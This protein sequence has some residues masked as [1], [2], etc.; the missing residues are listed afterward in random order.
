MTQRAFFSLREYPELERVRRQWREIRDEGQKL[1]RDMVWIEDERTN[2]RVWAFAPLKPENVDRTPQ[3]DAMSIAFR[4]KAPETVRLVQTIPRVLGYGFSLLLAGSR[5][6]THAHVNP[7][8][9]AMLGLSVGDSCWLTVG[10]ETYKIRPGHIL[11]FDYTLPHEVSNKS[12]KDR[13]VLLILLPNK[14]LC[15][16]GKC[17]RGLH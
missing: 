15:T 6:D 2:G 8:V 13:L 12:S 16:S 7:Y 17:A 14:S 9:T 3:L 11:T 4:A 1:R 10:H 5:I